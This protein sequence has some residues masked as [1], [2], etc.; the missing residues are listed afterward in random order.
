MIK[1][2][3]TFRANKAAYNRH[4]ILGAPICLH[5]SKEFYVQMDAMSDLIELCKREGWEIEVDAVYTSS[6]EQ[7]YNEVLDNSW[8]DKAA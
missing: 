2:T 7:I 5:E 6:I 3:I 1:V 4:G 8:K